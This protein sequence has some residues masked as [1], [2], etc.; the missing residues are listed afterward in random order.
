MSGSSCSFVCFL[1]AARLGSPSIPCFSVR[2]T[3]QKRVSPT[4]LSSFRGSLSLFLGAGVLTWRTLSGPKTASGL[5]CG[6]PGAL[7][8]SEPRPHSQERDVIH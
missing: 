1:Q 4:W 6:V 5:L 3:D 7:C 8:V 2:L